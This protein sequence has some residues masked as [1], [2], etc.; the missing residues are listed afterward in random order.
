MAPPDDLS[1]VRFLRSSAPLVRSIVP[2]RNR[3]TLLLCA[4]TVGVV[5]TAIVLPQVTPSA[6]ATGGAKPKP[7]VA[8]ESVPPA[9][10]ATAGQPTTVMDPANPKARGA[11]QRGLDFLAREAKTWQDS[12][13]CYGCHV[14]A[15]TLEA[16]VVG[17]HNQYELPDKD[18][19]SVLGGMLDV[20][21]GVRH[22][23][24][25]SYEDA[26]LLAP[27]KAFG[28]AAFAHYDQWIDSS[29]RND[30]VKTAQE[31]L[32]YQKPDG[33]IELTWNNPPVGAGAIQGT[34][35]AAQTWQQV[36]ARTADNRWLLPLQHA[37]AFLRTAALAAIG[38][39]VD[40]I[41]QLD[42][43]LMGLGATGVGSSDDILQKLAKRVTSR[44]AQD[45]GWGF[46]TGAD[47]NA[48]ATGQ[49]LYALRVAGFTDR[50]AVLQRGTA[51]LIAHQAQ[52]GGWSHAGS[53]KAEAMWGVLGLVSVD[54][55]SV[56]S[57]DLQDGDH[58]A[59][60]QQVGLEARDNDPA[61]GGVTRVELLIDD[62]RVK[63]VCGAKLAYAW[64]TTGTEAGKHVL[65]LLATNAKGLTSRRRLEVYAGAVYLTQIG[66]RSSDQTTEIS[67]RNIAAKGS[68]SV[69]EMQVMSGDKVVATISKPSEPGA[70]SFAWDGKTS[71]G[72]VASNG[73]Y[74]ARLAFRTGKDTVQ[75]EDVPF[76][77][78]TEAAQH[79]NYGEVQG[80]IALPDGAAGA[81]AP[82]ELVDDNDNVIQK[83]RSTASGQYRF[84][85]V[86][87]GKYKIRVM[88]KGFEKIEAPV[89]A[90]VAAEAKQDLKLK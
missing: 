45:G 77:R 85:G 2:M 16:F 70:M 58:V 78:G 83:T 29:L 75:T 9:I 15:V 27:S 87:A 47:S 10:C 51:W 19:K 37:E 35:Q 88:K 64:D 33:S 14:H 25:F 57:L 41:Q 82:I 55:L 48:F 66:A 28:G 71:S 8:S 54:V 67:L 61:G 60:H 18:M 34:Y 13:K 52:D 74:T 79:D 17:R 53:G 1:A 46:T 69:V 26:S 12:H 21:G 4:A 84:K 80:Q 86:D 76:V 81:N 40:D 43:A 49:A 59:D 56:A 44:Q 90:S 38:S 62:V 6:Q 63:S 22:K 11:A 23:L 3:K 65:D 7:P 5:V 32:A 68:A 24:G 72:T 20:P 39:N 50:D 31:L 73:K 42:Y 30:L 89:K 36:Y